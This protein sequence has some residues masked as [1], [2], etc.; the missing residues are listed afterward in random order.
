MAEDLI[1]EIATTL[2]IRQY[3]HVWTATA[4]E[5]YGEGATPIEAVRDLADGIQDRIRARRRE[6][7]TDAH[8]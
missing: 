4:G 7:A 2:T 6:E 1:Q 8:H 5:A 3:P